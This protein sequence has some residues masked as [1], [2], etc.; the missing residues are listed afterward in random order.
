MGLSAGSAP[1]HFRARETE[2]L[3][4]VCGAEERLREYRR[5]LPGGDRSS[6]LDGIFWDAVVLTAANATQAHVYVAQLDALHGRGQLPGKRAMYLVIA[7]PR[8]PRVGS[9]GATLNVML[10]LQAIAGSGW[11]TKKVFLLHAGGYAERSPAHGTLGK[12][13]GQIPMDAANLGVPATILEAQ[14][15]AF[16]DLAKILPPG[17]FV[18]SADVAVQFGKLP[19]LD[20]DDRAQCHDGVLA[21]A[22][23]SCLDTGTGH[24]VF[25]CDRGEVGNLVSNTFSGSAFMASGAG[26]ATITEKTEQESVKKK[27]A[28]RVAC[29]TVPA[30]TPRVPDARIRRS[31]CQPRRHG[32]HLWE[33]RRVGVNRQRVPHRRGRVRGANTGRRDEPRRFRRRRDLRVRRLH[34]A[35]G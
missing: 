13:F 32:P 3:S 21:L 24:G 6:L 33:L 35:H 29:E 23:A 2:Q 4:M 10:Q 11:G 14:L 30:E 15:V 22:H 28:Q 25:V 34:A 12:A 26:G 9:G 18:S 8:G 17:V 7:D 19:A 31:A 1:P 5:M 20:N 27:A 16:T